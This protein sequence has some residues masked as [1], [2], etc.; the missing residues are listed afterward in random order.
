[1]KRRRFYY[2]LFFMFMGIMISNAQ[3]PNRYKEQVDQLYNKEYNF[4][5]EKQLVVFAGSS[6]IRMWK[7]VQNYFPKYNVINNGFGGSQYSD[8]IHYY[9][10]LILKQKP[11]ILFV[12]EGDND[13]AANKKPA[14]V[15]KEA[16]EIIKNV[17][18][19]LPET[20]ILLISTKPS[21]LRWG[22]RDKYVKLN[23]RLYKLSKRRNIEYVDIWN[24]MLD[25]TGN[26][27]EDIFLH[28]NIHMNKKGYDLWAKKIN[29]VLENK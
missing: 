24:T 23:K 8:L 16:K 14:R 17:Q 27:Y 10:K 21:I 9:D 19:D 4:N 11:D 13:I 3:D 6:S 22:L 26:V 7:D 20:E 5:N 25:E 2:L 1:M 18:A 15:A 28:D 12:Y 29:Q